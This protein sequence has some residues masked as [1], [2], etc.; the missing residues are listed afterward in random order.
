MNNKI[1]GIILSGGRSSR[2]GED[3]ALLKVGTKTIIEIM[4]DK[5]KPFCNEIIISADNVEKYSKFG[6]KVVPDK[7]KNSGPLAGIYSSLLESNT[8]RNFVIS[9]DLPLVSQNVIEKIINTNSDKEIILPITDGKYH[10]LCGVYSKSVLERAKEILRKGEEEKGRRGEREKGSLKRKTSVKSLLN[11]YEIEFV[12]V[13][14]IA[15]ENE[16]LNMNSVEEYQEIYSFLA[17]KTDQP[18]KI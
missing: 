3:K 6:Y 2:M 18:F 14:S 11:N 16:F 4:I 1:N 12:D 13:T 17:N 5:L 15:K 10:Q 8:E 7:F 9:C